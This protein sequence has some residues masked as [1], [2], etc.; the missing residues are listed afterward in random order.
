MDA[1]VA[2]ELYLR[3]DHLGVRLRAH[4][5]S[6]LELAKNLEG[7][8]IRVLHPGLESHP[9]FSLYRKILNPGLGAGAMMT[10]DCGTSAK[11]MELA[12][13]LQKEKFGLYAVSLGF[14]R[15]LMS[16]PS[17]STSSEIPEADQKTMGLSP[18]LL[19]LSVGY[20]GDTGILSQRFLDSWKAVGLA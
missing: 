7:A 20:L 1:R 9:Q 17:V 14:S 8:G 10:L 19:R 15:T 2:H 13:H 18:G 3:L 6:S 4:S 11:A 12:F 5:E 16:C